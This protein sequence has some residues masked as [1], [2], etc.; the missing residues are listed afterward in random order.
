M[1]ELKES[2]NSETSDDTI[3]SSRSS[4]DSSPPTKSKSKKSPKRHTKKSHKAKPKRH[5]KKSH[6]AKAK[7]SSTR[8]VTLSSS[9]SSESLASTGSESSDCKK[10]KKFYKKH[11]SKPGSKKRTSCL[12]DVFRKHFDSLVSLL[13]S[14]LIEITNKLFSK[15]FI[16]KDM[17][18]QVLTGQESQ[19]TKTALL[20]STI[21]KLILKHS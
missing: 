6:K 12:L 11:E 7:K 16:S 15:K 2:T 18:N 4:L 14:C 3:T 19:K 10:M 17:L 8:R 13:M 21:W 20:L 1:A 5:T 9:S